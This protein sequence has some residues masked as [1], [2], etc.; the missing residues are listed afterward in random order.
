M[1]FSNKSKNIK[2][3]RFNS[4]CIRNWLLTLHWGQ[5]LNKLS[6]LKRRSCEVEDLGKQITTHSLIKCTTVFPT[7]SH[8]TLPKPSGVSKVI[9]GEIVCFIIFSSQSQLRLWWRTLTSGRGCFFY[10]KAFFLEIGIFQSNCFRWSIIVRPRRRS[11]HVSH[12]S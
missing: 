10:H 1:C 9:W 8:S 4:A 5:P 6:T 11:P 2:P 12:A 3:Q 7:Q